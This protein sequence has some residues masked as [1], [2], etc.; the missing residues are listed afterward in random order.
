MLSA[1]FH[2]GIN[3]VEKLQAFDKG[4]G[5]LQ[6]LQNFDKGII[7]IQKFSEFY[8]SQKLVFNP[9]AKIRP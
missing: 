4:M 7:Q 9:G 8:K 5:Q 6:N 1:N 2:T 3:Q